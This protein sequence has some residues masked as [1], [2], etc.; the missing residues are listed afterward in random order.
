MKEIKINYEIELKS[1]DLKVIEEK[2][3]SL[4]MS[5]SSII[6]RKIK[7]QF[8]EFWLR[9]DDFNLLFQEKNKFF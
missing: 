4:K 8:G 5:N 3:A 7:T 1:S 6:A 2:I 9:E